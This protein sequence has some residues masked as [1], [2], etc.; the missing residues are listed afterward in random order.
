M[1]ADVG[2][3]VLIAPIPEL[4]AVV[5]DLRRRYDRA[6][7][8]RMGAHV[9]LIH[10]FPAGEQLAAAIDRVDDVAAAIAPMDLVVERVGRFPTS[11]YLA[12]TPAQPLVR[13]ESA[14]RRALPGLAP[15]GHPFIPHVS[16]A[17]DR[18]APLAEVATKLATMVP[19]AGRVDRLMVCTLVGGQWTTAH[20]TSLTG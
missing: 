9:T 13:L 12:P 15:P 16:V 11:V 14:L 4:D 2:R 17:R 7:R 10:P 5:G 1:N 8:R 19:L 18:D 20:V 6:A 3:T